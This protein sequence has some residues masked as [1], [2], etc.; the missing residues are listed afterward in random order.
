MTYDPAIRRATI[1]SAD[2]MR[3]LAHP[4]RLAI[5]LY[6]LSGEAR[7]ATE[8]ADE[9]AATPSACSYHLRELERF[10]FVERADPVDDARA[11]PWRATA[12]GFSVGGD[13][14]D[15]TPVASAAREVIG[16]AEAAENQRLIAP[17]L[18]AVDELDDAWRAAVDFHTFELVVTP[19]ELSRLNAEVAHLLRPFRPAD[20]GDAPDAAR[21][22]HVVFQAFPRMKAR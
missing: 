21:A 7:T 6:L 10:G 14:T 11:R 9:V 1:D 13:W 3:A 2:A 16:Y 19:S 17:F 8:C 15:R 4:D 12:S 18:D 5:L 22:V 20:R